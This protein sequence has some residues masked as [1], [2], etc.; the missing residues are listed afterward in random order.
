MYGL[1]NRLFFEENLRLNTFLQIIGIIKHYAY[2]FCSYQFQL[3]GYLKK[4]KGG[5]RRK[6]RYTNILFVNS[7]ES[8]YFCFDY[9]EHAEV[10]IL[11]LLGLFR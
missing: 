3:Q 5:G 10:F 1:F 7:P 8:L 11:E 6:N 9:F 4:K 2:K